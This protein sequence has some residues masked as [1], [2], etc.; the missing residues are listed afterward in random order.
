MEMGGGMSEAS[1]GIYAG[2]DLVAKA[3][4]DPKL[5]SFMD[6]DGTT[7]SYSDNPSDQEIEARR[8]IREILETYGGYVLTTARTPELCMSERVLQASRQA[9]FTRLDPKCYIENGTH[10]YRPLSMIRKYAYLNDPDAIH[11]IGEGAWI[12]REDAF[13]LDAEF[14]ERY[15]VERQKWK[16][17]M[18]NLIEYVDEDW[19]I[20][21]GFSKL[22]DP[23]SHKNGLVD[24]QE[25]E[26]RFEITAKPG[27]DG[28]GWKKLVRER[29]RGLC[30]TAHPLASVSQSI[31]F[32]D[33][34]VPPERYQLYLVP[35]KRLT[36]EGAFNHILRQVSRASGVPTN[37]FI[38]LSS[39][40]RIPDLK[41]GLF[42]GNKGYFILPGGSVL[43]EYLVGSKKGQDFAGQ[44]LKSIVRRLKPLGKKG[45]YRF[46]MLGMSY[47]RIVIIADEAV[48]GG[49]TDAESIL[50]VLK[51]ING[52][53]V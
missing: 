17:D 11:S 15:Q 25:L 8:E 33:E 44:S 19:L 10:E 36:K 6:I 49:K 37:E 26:C 12:K 18:R 53:L 7:A 30:G 3:G 23:D 45:W 35:H 38:T 24:V 47:P 14:Y 2:S 43:T 9:G 41:A 1:A 50:A 29:L 13:Y 46:W 22:E 52:N 32:I 31:G 40:D 16:S 27:V 20:R 42:G 4:Q 5:L 34:S 51:D 21:D 28:P 48:R 39:G